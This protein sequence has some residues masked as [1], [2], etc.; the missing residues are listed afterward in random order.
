MKTQIWTS[1]HIRTRTR[2]PLPCG[3]VSRRS[4]RA[5]AAQRSRR[6]C[7]AR[8]TRA[9]TLGAQSPSPRRT[10]SARHTRCVD[11]DGLRIIFFGMECMRAHVLALTLA[12]RLFTLPTAT[13]LPDSTNT[14]WSFC[15]CCALDN[16]ATPI[17]HSFMQRTRE[18]L[19]TSTRHRPR[20]RPPRS[21]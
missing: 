12:E 5:C 6:V 17:H 20:P 9:R 7:T 10:G 18:T 11:G 13:A 8:T 2:K 19:P 3:A 16:D 15:A 21:T 1:P 14:A 4:R